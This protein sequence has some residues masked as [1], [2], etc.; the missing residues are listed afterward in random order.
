MQAAVLEEKIDVNVVERRITRDG[1]PF[2][3]YFYTT[4]KR[5]SLRAELGHHT[6]MHINL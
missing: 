3:A 2:K 5:H 1:I 6:Q 4:K